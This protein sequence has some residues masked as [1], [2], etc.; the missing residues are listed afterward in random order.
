MKAILAIVV[1]L[2]AGSLAQ[3]QDT[4]IPVAVSHAGAEGVG[5]QIAVALKEAIRGSS[6]F[7]LVD[8]EVSPEFARIVVHLTSV[9]APDSN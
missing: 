3:A 5:G 4:R 2:L 6:S 1:L 9:T 8:D 7:R